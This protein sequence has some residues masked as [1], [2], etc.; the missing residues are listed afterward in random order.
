LGARQAGFG[1]LAGVFLQQ[2]RVWWLFWGGLGQEKWQKNAKIR[3]LVYF[4]VTGVLLQRIDYRL[5]IF[6]MHHNRCN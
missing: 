4:M 5:V 1:R 3:R 6:S 2:K